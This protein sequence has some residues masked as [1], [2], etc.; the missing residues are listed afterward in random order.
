[1]ITNAAFC[2]PLEQVRLL[3]GPYYDAMERNRQYLLSLDA[4]RL[5]HMFRIT[6]GLPSDAKP[7]GGWEEPNCEIRGHTLGHYL[8]ACALMYA[9]TG[10]ETIKSQ[11]DGIISEL[12]QCQVAMPSQGY[13]KGYLF[14]FPES[15]FDRVDARKPV[16]VPWYTCHKIMQGLIDMY[17][18]CGNTQALDCVTAMA[19][20]VAFRTGRLSPEQM[21]LSLD[22]EFGG[23]NDVMAS[24]YAISGNSVHLACAKRFDH[25]KIYDPLA[26]GSDRLK[27]LHANTQIPKIVGAAREYEVTG[28]SRYREIAEFFWEQV[29]R[30]RSY[31]QGGTSN[32]E[33]WRTK[34]EMLAQ[35]LS[36]ES[37]ESCCTYNMLKLT[38]HLFCWDPQAYFAD[39]YER[40]LLNHILASQSPE[41]GMMMYYVS[42]KPGYWKVFNTPENAFWCC[43]GSGMENHAKYGDSIY[44]HNGQ[45]LWVSQFISSELDWREMDTVIR[46][47]TAFPENDITSLTISCKKPVELDIRIRVPWWIAGPVTID[48]NGDNKVYPAEPS[49]YLSLQQIWHNGDNIRITLPMSL[50]L[51]PMPDDDSVAAVMY[52]PAVLAGSLGREELTRDMQYLDNQR[53]MH[54]GPEIEVPVL[55]TE[56]R[57]PAEWLKPVDGSPLTFRTHGV[58][59]PDDVTL[60]PFYTLYDQRYTLY[61][62]FLTQQEYERRQAEQKVKKAAARARKEKLARCTVDHI[63]FNNF[64]SEQAHGLTAEKSNSGMHAGKGWRDAHNGGWFSYT[65]K[66]LPDKDMELLCRYWGSDF[67]RVFHIIVDDRDIALVTLNR[68]H[69]D[70]FFDVTYPLPRELTDGKTSLRVTIRAHE[71][72]VAGGLFGCRTLHKEESPDSPGSTD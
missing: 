67:G 70:Q 22:T 19:D 63:E 8:T 23:M 49:T 4:D 35:E 46:Q 37:A 15:F 14:A 9:S 12:L 55:V 72:N 69:P 25:K 32:F 20:W 47:E 1:M 18:Y 39:Y 21:Q 5:L 31:A 13:N 2:F 36:V 16:W 6:A 64:A 26:D 42:M 45:I 57:P 34:P 24:L 52:G 44:F 61:W 54:H 27:G 29:A 28:N 60:V 7:Y 41:N 11:A 58:G 30:K 62:A 48:I 43:T 50:H 59:R 71:G 65:L 10:D 56:G 3:P 51:A 53:G 68:D 38:R 17:L 33:H 66:S 40:A